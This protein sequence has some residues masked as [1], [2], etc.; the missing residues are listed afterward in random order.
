MAKE[1]NH[2]D[3]ARLAASRSSS[4]NIEVSIN[5]FE[6]SIKKKYEKKP[7][8]NAQ[9]AGGSISDVSIQEAD[10]SSEESEQSM[11]F[12]DEMSPAEVIQPLVPPQTIG[13]SHVFSSKS[14]SGGFS[15]DD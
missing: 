15:F 5:I 2:N 9:V 1:G 11:E 8:I 14:F 6:E 7:S 10:S 13:S 4:L 12:P 3:Q